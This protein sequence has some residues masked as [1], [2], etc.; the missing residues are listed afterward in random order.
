MGFMQWFPNYGHCTSSVFTIR[1]IVGNASSWAWS[2]LLTQQSV[3]ASFQVILRHG[4]VTAPPRLHAFS[5]FQPQEGGI[6]RTL[7]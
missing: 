2:D 5:G 4:Q 1:F 6:S 3:L 7:W